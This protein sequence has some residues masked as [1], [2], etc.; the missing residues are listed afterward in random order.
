M[1]DDPNNEQSSQIDDFNRR[2]AIIA[3][4]CFAIA[5]P[6]GAVPKRALRAQSRARRNIEAAIKAL[7]PDC[8][9]NEKREQIVAAK[10]CHRS[11]PAAAL[12]S[13]SPAGTSPA[14][15]PEESVPTSTPQ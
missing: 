12:A 13:P 1:A 5:A 2:I 14:P 7:P 6:A 9:C 8:S 11:Q 15:T 3:L 4:L 10:M